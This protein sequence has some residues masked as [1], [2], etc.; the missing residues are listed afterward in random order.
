MRAKNKNDFIYKKKVNIV[1]FYFV[2]D[3][4]CELSSWTLATSWTKHNVVEER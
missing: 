4:Y 3:F 1:D 2:V